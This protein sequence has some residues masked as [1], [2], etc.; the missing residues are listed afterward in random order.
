MSKSVI[1]AVRAVFVAASAVVACAQA[2]AITL[3]GSVYSNS[4]IRSQL[5]TVDT[6]TG[7][8]TLIGGDATAFFPGL[9]ISSA[10]GLLGSGSSLWIVNPSS[11]HASAIG[12]LP[13]LV[14]SIAF[15]LQDRLW[16]IGNG[17]GTLW[18]LDATTGQSIAAGFLSGLQ[19]GG[20]RSIAF[21]NQGTLFGIGQG[22]LYKV[23]TT[24]FSATAIA[25]ITP[26][27]TVSGLTFASDGRLFTSQGTNLFSTSTLSVV[28]I[29]TGALSPIGPSTTTPPAFFVE[30]LA[31]PVTAVPEAGMA[32][33][34]AAGLLVLAFK[35]R[36]RADA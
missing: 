36:Q 1:S 29:G 6:D 34:L 11:G 10:G 20:I 33:M 14:V 12:T 13:E 19:P 3:Y 26:C 24:T 31:A 32:A 7:A 9:A 22:V 8:A 35:R 15:D 27:C 16:G 18:Q 17:T 23:N 4:L 28:N 5:Y 30:G 2:S 25:A 21:D